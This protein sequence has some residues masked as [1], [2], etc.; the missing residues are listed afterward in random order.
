MSHPETEVVTNDSPKAEK[1]KPKG[2]A[3]KPPLTGEQYRRLQQERKKMGLT[4]AGLDG[5]ELCKTCGERESKNMGFCETCFVEVRKLCNLCQKNWVGP[6]FNTCLSC[7]REISAC[8]HCHQLKPKDQIWGELC[9][10]CFAT[11]FACMRCNNV[12]TT[13]P[14]RICRGCTAQGLLCCSACRAPTTRPGL[15]TPCHLLRTGHVPCTNCT[16]NFTKHSSR[17]CRDCSVLFTVCTECKGEC[18]PHG[19]KQSGLCKDCYG[20]KHTQS[21]QYKWTENGKQQQCTNTA[22]FPH[23]FCVGCYES[24]QSNRA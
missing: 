20:K 24:I 11:M 8:R 21:C 12:S 22:N 5:L 10:P 2:N 18:R 7:S 23:R 17:L 9:K 3:T 16:V 15:C 19:V 14:S 13:H 1:N 4:D 6:R